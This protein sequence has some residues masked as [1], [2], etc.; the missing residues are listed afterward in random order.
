MPI[1]PQLWL[2]ISDQKGLKPQD[3]TDIYRR[4]HEEK[5]HPKALCIYTHLLVVHF[6]MAR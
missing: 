4:Q 2:L 5:L 1:C 3:P 6:A